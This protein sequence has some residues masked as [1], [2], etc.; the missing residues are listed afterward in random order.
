MGIRE[1]LWT[2]IHSM[3]NGMRK[4]RNLGPATGINPGKALCPSLMLAVCGCSCLESPP[5]CPGL[6]TQYCSSL[7]DT[8]IYLINSGVCPELNQTSA[9][10]MR[11]TIVFPQK[12]IASLL[13]PPLP[14]HLPFSSAVM[15]SGLFITLNI[16][17]KNHIS[18]A[19]WISNPAL[20]FSPH[21]LS[22]SISGTSPV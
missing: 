3:S 5:H 1:R 10:N 15:L 14:L 6:G 22:M 7:W 20:K 12:Q 16:K 13:V 21:H 18:F 2:F 9:E 19:E 11:N 4:L 8:V 17:K